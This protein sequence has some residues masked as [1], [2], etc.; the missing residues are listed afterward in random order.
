M[1]NVVFLLLIFFMLAGAFQTAGPF[2]IDAPTSSSEA[3]AED[4][5]PV[6]LLD[7][8]GRLALGE[9]E[10][11]AQALRQ[12]LAARV[13]ERPELVVRLKADGRVST[14]RVVEAMELMRA[15]GVQR[16]MLLTLQPEGR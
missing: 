15:A 2:E 6:V 13:A 7:R 5:D 4:A 16:L 9:K 12:A 8:D 11:D 3:A 1:I 14:P 10:V